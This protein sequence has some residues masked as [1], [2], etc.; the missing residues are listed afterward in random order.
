MT[1]Q[2][3]ARA[4]RPPSS[5]KP[6]T[7]LNTNNPALTSASQ[8]SSASTG[9]VSS[10]S[11]KRFTLQSGWESSATPT[12]ASTV[13]SS[14]TAGPAAAIRNSSPGDCE[15]RESL[16]SP[17]KTQRSMPSTSMPLRRATTAWPSSC[18][19]ID[20]KNSSAPATAVT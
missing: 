10:A 5:G 11:A 18:R 15:S 19:A 12:A 4:I 20:K 3:I 16:A 1:F 8:L 2:A 9:V 14:V 6:G 7:R 13:I 17:P